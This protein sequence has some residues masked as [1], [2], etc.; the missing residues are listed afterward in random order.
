MSLGDNGCQGTV[1]GGDVLH[2]TCPFRFVPASD[3][4]RD[5]A[6]LVLLVPCGD[7][8]CTLRIAACVL[9]DI[10]LSVTGRTRDSCSRLLVV[11]CG[12]SCVEILLD[13]ETCA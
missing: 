4:V 11:E 3:I 5:W 7:L 10:L 1:D 8:V 2:I 12:W 13:G 9:G 6:S